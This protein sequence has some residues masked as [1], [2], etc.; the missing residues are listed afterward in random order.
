MNELQFQIARLIEVGRMRDVKQLLQKAFAEAPHDP[1]LHCLAARAALRVDDEARAGEHVAEAL[2]AD[3]THPDARVLH[4]ALRCAARD[5]AEAERTITE[6]I[7]EAPHNGRLLALYAEL[8]LTTMHLDKARA[9]IEEALRRAPDDEHA[10]LVNVLMLIVDG[11]RAAAGD[12]LADL[13]RGNPEGAEVTRTL[14]NV[15]IEQRRHREALAIGR[16]LL[17]L[18]PD[19]DELID[20]LA[21]LAAMTHW[22][23]LPAYPLR[24][25]GW[26]GTAGL[27]VIGGAGVRLLST[28][29]LTLALGFT[30]L[31]L[32][33]VLYSWIHLPLLKRWLLRRGF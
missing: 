13:I 21:A 28:V 10:R 26:I 15:L 33:Y 30:A 27:W 20:S 19:N 1:N 3:P 32:L 31:Y 12:Q 23:S 4:F 22:I 6:L 18:Y 9:L 14:Y 11:D 5:Y 24:R 29:D 8:M 2:A 17:K 7:R 16:Q 25:F